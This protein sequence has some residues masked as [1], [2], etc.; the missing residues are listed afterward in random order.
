MDQPGNEDP[1]CLAVVHQMNGIDLVWTVPPD[2]V[3]PMHGSDQFGPL[4]A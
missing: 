2:P 4:R 3:H 1:V